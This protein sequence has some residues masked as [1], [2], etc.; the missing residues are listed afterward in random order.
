MAKLETQALITVEK[1]DRKYSFECAHNSNL[2]E[3]YDV[4]QE[5]KYYIYQ[6]IQEL[7]ANQS[8]KKVEPIQEAN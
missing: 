6:R 5:M 2:G 3:I 1:E 7:E 4:L 8:E